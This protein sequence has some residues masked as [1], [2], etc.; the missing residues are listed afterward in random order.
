MKSKHCFGLSARMKCLVA[1]VLI[2]A[3]CMGTGCQA[4]LATFLMLAG[5]ME[6]KAKYKCFKGKKVA[7]ACTSETMAD[8]RYDDVPKDLAKAVGLHLSQNV[9]KI[10]IIPAA[11]VNKW[12]DRHDGKIEDPQ[13]FGK[14]MEADMVMIIEL[15]SFETSSPS[16]PGSC[17]GR[18][19]TSFIVYEVKTGEMQAAE[20]LPEYVYPPNIRQTDVR[21][22]EFKKRY[23]VQ[24]SQMISRHFYS[25]DHRQNMAMDAHAGLGM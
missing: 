16:S 18:A 2:A 10:E 13:E 4:M 5:G 9:K 24:L 1:C 8:A 22:S 14:D 15:A 6:T 23:L 3:I 12:L 19:S 7:V 11:K 21:E 25:Y 20:T 17:Q